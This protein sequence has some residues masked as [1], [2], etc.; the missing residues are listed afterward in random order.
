[1]NLQQI[2]IKL[3][4]IQSDLERYADIAATRSL[5]TEE[6]DDV[7][8]LRETAKDMTTRQQLLAGR[9]TTAAN[10]SISDFRTALKESRETGAKRRVTSPG[11]LR[12]VMTPLSG[13]AGKTAYS[14]VKG[15]QLQETENFAWIERL[16]NLDGVRNGTQYPYIGRNN[17]VT[18]QNKGYT[19][20]FNGQGYIVD[21]H[22][23][24]LKNYSVFLQVHNDVFRDAA[25]DDLETVIL[26][27]ARADVLRQIA[28]DVLVGDA[29]SNNIDGIANTAGVQTFAHGNYI[30][31]FSPVVRAVRRLMTGANLADPS[32]AIAVMH[33]LLWEQFALLQGATD[34]QPLQVPPAIQGVQMYPYSRLS[35]TEGNDQDS[36]TMFVFVPSRWNLFTEGYFELMAATGPDMDRDYTNVHVL[37][38]ADVKSIDPA[39]ACLVTGIIADGSGAA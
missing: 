26:G 6:R 36:S 21:S 12:S 22:T 15:V 2:E 5:T 7:N 30:S 25:T 37:L 10:P 34:G 17:R 29:S 28:Y 11:F 31:D 23:V 27:A 18:A 32:Q 3:Q 20:A 1:M 38:R 35:V 13:S 24:Q 4:G 33:P 14:E 16:N 9:T 8:R 39:A 19:D